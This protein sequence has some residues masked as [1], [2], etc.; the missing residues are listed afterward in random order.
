ME[1]RKKR[2]QKCLAEIFPAACIS[3]AQAKDGSREP[4]RHG[5]SF[6]SP[7]DGKA[8]NKSTLL[9]ISQSHST[10]YKKEKKYSQKLRVFSSCHRH[11]LRV[12]SSFHLGEQQQQQ[13][14][15][16]RLRLSLWQSKAKR[17]VIRPELTMISDHEIQFS[18]APRSPLWS[19]SLERLELPPEPPSSLS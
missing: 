18:G 2:R 9:N 19:P 1:G 17:S 4:E 15:H 13:L 8:P 12:Y 10:C 6:F 11:F 7:I 14:E 3:W 5:N 16:F